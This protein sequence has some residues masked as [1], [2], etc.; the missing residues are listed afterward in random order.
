PSTDGIQQIADIL[1][2]NDLHELATISIVSHGAPGEM[3]LGSTMLTDGNLADHSAALAGIGTALGSG[4]TLQL[5]GCDIGQGAVGQQ[6]I[7]DLSALAGGINVAAATHD[8]GSASMGRSWTLD[9][10]AAAGTILNVAPVSGTAASS[11]PAAASDPGGT[12]APSIGVLAE[13]PSQS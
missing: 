8:V 3:V 1:A 2:A 9:V 12:Q 10:A 11:D 6:F 7:N 5:F 4:G 13:S